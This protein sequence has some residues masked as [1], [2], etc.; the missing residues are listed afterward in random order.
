MISMYRISAYLEKLPSLIKKEL[1]KEMMDTLLSESFFPHQY[2]FA[3]EIQII[4]C[5]KSKHLW[6]T[7]HSFKFPFLSLKLQFLKHTNFARCMKFNIGLRGQCTFR[8]LNLHAMVTL[9]WVV[10]IVEFP[11]LFVA[12]REY[13]FP[14][15]VHNGGNTVRMAVIS[16]S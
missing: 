6:P 4:L 14:V 1:H 15:S 12:Y 11:F 7:L 5:F 13:L 16:Q 8:C 10:F 9:Q 2:N 3:K